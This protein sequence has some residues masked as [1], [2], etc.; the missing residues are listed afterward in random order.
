MATT[1]VPFAVF[2]RKGY[3]MLPLSPIENCAIIQSDHLCFRVVFEIRG[4]LRR[5]A[6]TCPAA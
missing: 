4:G 3:A 6:S 2:H 1:D 5:S